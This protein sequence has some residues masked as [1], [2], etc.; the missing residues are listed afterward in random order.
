M[1]LKK[2]TRKGHGDVHIFIPISIGEMGVKAGEI[3]T[4]FY[5]IPH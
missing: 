4:A 2:T 1:L 3:H 5:I